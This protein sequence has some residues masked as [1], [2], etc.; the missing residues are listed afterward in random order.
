MEKTFDFKSNFILNIKN[1][2]EDPSLDECNIN[3]CLI[4]LV[5]WIHSKKLVTLQVEQLLSMQD[6]DKLLYVATKG[7]FSIYQ[8]C[9]KFFRKRL[10]VLSEKIYSEY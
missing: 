2:C 7:I 1:R 3:G 6:H 8:S 4:F 10:T 5:Q 9:S